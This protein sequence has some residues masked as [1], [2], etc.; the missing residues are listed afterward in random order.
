MNAPCLLQFAL[1]S[2]AVATQA[3]HALAQDPG[4]TPV[5][6]LNGSGVL[7]AEP[8]LP[9]SEAVRVGDEVFLSGM[10]GFRPGTL[11]LVPGGTA[12]EARQT[13]EN[14]RA[15]LNAHG[16]SLSDIVKCTVMMEDI[17]EWSAFNEVYKTFFDAPY[18]ARTALGVDGL[19]VG[20]RVEVDCI[21]AVPEQTESQRE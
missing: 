13:M 21:A 9:F 5:E 17:S 4:R 11:E 20:A 18:P 12:A 1:L 6:Y 3:P 2:L 14:I 7:P 10:V 15:V 8:A 19:A 16:Y